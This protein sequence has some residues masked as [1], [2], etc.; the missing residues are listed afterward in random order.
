M[1]RLR[2][3]S[4]RQPGAQTA[5]TAEA[6]T[7]RGPLTGSRAAAAPSSAR[8]GRAPTSFPAPPARP[9]PRTSA[10]PGPVPPGPLGPGGPGSRCRLPRAAGN[11]RPAPRPLSRPGARARRGRRASD[12]GEYQRR[13]PHSLPRLAGAPG[14]PDSDHSALAGRS[15]V[16]HG[17]A[18]AGLYPGQRPERTRAP[19]PCPGRAD[20]GGL[21]RSAPA[22]YFPPP[23]RAPPLVLARRNASRCAAGG[24]IQRLLRDL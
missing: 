19:R 20:G 17:G 12:S 6:R 9:R 16:P 5:T 10:L 14:L 13:P 23:P 24:R 15:P 1:A 3:K 21:L 22:D 18:A 8:S 4:C 11:A 7:R 2:A